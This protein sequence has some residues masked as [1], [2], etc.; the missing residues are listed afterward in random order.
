MNILK[1]RY[2]IA[3]VTPYMYKAIEEGAR[4]CYLSEPKDTPKLRAEYIQYCTDNNQG[5]ADPLGVGFKN[6]VREQF[7]KKLMKMGHQTPFEHG[8]ITIDFI[9]DRGVSHEAVRH[10]MTSPMQE[11]TRYCDYQEG[12]KGHGMNVIHPLFFDTDDEKQYVTLPKLAGFQLEMKDSMGFSKAT[13]HINKFDVW[14]MCMQF[15]EWG[16]Q[17][18]RKMEASP[19]EA[20]SV[21]PNSLKTKLR[22]K[23]NVREWWHIFKLRAVNT[24]AHPQIREVMIPALKEC[25]ARWPIL[26]QWLLDEIKDDNP[27]S[28]KAKPKNGD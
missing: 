19:Q 15:A 2:E 10:R 25:A 21:L 17:T 5:Y 20:R 1:P 4:I 11:S 26:F 6:F 24:G 22:I 27:M 28:G 13:V 8:D 18:M 16:Y 23:A 12:E 9:C 14:F 3:R 7:I